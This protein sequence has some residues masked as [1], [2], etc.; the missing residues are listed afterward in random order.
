MQGEMVTAC[1]FQSLAQLGGE[2]R[3]IAQAEFGRDR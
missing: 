2:R 1:F 3:R